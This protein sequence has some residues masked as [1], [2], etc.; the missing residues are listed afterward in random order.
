M[1]TM[2]HR[3]EGKIIRWKVC[4]KKRIKLRNL[5]IGINTEAVNNNVPGLPEIRE[6][7]CDS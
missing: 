1:E 5:K 2:V 7:V 6:V 3:I 4:G